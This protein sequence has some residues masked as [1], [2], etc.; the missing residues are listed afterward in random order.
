MRPGTRIRRSVPARTT[1]AASL[2]PD[3]AAGAEAE[4]TTGRGP[5]ASG[6]GGSS[7][8]DGVGGGGGSGGRTQH[9]QHVVPHSPPLMTNLDCGVASSAPSISA[10][11]SRSDFMD[12]RGT[13]SQ[14]TASE[15][16]KLSDAAAPASHTS[17]IRK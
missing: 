7:G 13:M 2:L 3:A 6:R 17:W 11:S 8:D 10:D 9:G 5:A 16:M 4:A 14:P 15:V 12:S 1:F